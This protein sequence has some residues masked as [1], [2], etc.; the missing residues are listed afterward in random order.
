MQII[1]DVFFD[2]SLIVVSRNLL[3][4]LDNEGWKRLIGHI[5]K[6]LYEERI[7]KVG[8]YQVFIRK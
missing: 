5:M 8:Q 2:G 3:I 1:L 4:V 7:K 6:G